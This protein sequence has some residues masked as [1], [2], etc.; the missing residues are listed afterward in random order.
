MKRKIR[1]LFDP[2]SPL[3]STKSLI[4]FSGQKIVLPFYHAVSNNKL[5]HISN[6]YSSR[7]VEQFK[8][9]LDYLLRYYQPVSID[10]LHQFITHKKP[11]DKP[12]FHLT[13]DDGL[14]E[15]K[16]VIAPILK[17]KGIP[18]TVFLNTDFIDNKD[19]F[20]RYKI[21]LIIEKL[22][23][24][25]STED[26]G[27]VAK[28]I[29]TSTDLSIC[30]SEILKLQFHQT[31]LINQLGTLLQIDFNHYLTTEKPY[32]T[33]SEI[34]ELEKQGFTFGSHSTNHP[35]FS[36]LTYS[37]QKE[38]IIQSFAFLKEKLNIEGNYFSF[39]F[40]DDGVSEKFMNWL[41]QLPDMKLS[42]GTA[43]IKNDVH[44]NHLQRLPMEGNV[45]RPAQI[46]NSEY[47]YFLVKKLLNKNRIRRR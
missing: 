28:T 13:F 2:I 46:I 19:L 29:N 7:N 24:N 20:Y 12:I 6:L 14:Q 16:S 43:G 4:K 21:S 41:H 18:A 34:K 8:A 33:S 15:I 36:Q 42:F 5:A 25:S 44:K 32:L 38:E 3:F 37:E 31:A 10:E 1:A 9:D 22:K 27:N 39:P 35:L 47:L 26:L 11:V 23:T 40:S 17:E 30:I 45:L